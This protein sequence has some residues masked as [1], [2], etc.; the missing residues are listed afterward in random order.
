MSVAT[1]IK[2]RPSIVRAV[3]VTVAGVAL[4]VTLGL[5]SSPAHA[6]TVT[7]TLQVHVDG[8]GDDRW[9]NAWINVYLPMNRYD[10]QGYIN[11]GA[12]VEIAC[13]GD[14]YF[15]D[16]DLFGVNRYVATG[17]GS[18]QYLLPGQNVWLSNVNRLYATDYGVS[19]QAVFSAEYLKVAAS[20]GLGFNED[21]GPFDA[22][23]I[24]CLATWIDGDGARAG[25]FTNVVS[26]DF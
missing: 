5:A 13:W 16:D 23:E 24:Y 15:S 21:T 18:G 14:D 25:D 12:R 1:R 26:G 20:P 4:V 2:I 3:T 17:S 6:A 9:T 8:A 7:A 11:N 10:A 19:L 22:D